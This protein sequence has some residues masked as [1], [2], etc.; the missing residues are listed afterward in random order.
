MQE[1]SR[2]CRLK[3]T[4]NLPKIEPR[5]PCP[6]KVYQKLYRYLDE[7]LPARERRSARPPRTK[8]VF[9]T[10]TSSPA[11]PRTPVKAVPSRL[12][13]SRTKRSQTLGTKIAEVPKWVM[14]AIR[15]LC[16]GL[17]APAAPHHIFAGVSSIISTS[18]SDE[19]KT[20]ALIIAVYVFAT[21]RLSGIPFSSGKFPQLRSQALKIVTTSAGEDAERGDVDDAD[22]DHC[23]RE[24]KNQQW[25]EMDWFENIPAGVGVGTDEGIEE[26]VDDGLDDEE[27]EE[28][29]LLPVKRRDNDRSGAAHQDYLQAGLGTMVRPSF[30]LNRGS[31][32][33][34]LQMQDRVDY[35]SD[36]RR[37]GFREWKRNI[38]L[39]IEELEKGE[40]MDVDVG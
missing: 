9:S 31:K 6:P 37:R 36:D 34:D 2:G 28:G 19:I 7:A 38:L 12:S 29:H 21:T 24:V 10:P 26:P 33:T 14:P 4:L 40:E 35:L 22:V 20:P 17:G 8:D 23:M 30:K 5:P 15:Q 18:P 27:T 1:L 39:E 25:T 32:L 3:Q 11:K 13:A 16:N